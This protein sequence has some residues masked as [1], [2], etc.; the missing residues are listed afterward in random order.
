MACGRNASIMGPATMPISCRTNSRARSYEPGGFTTSM[1]GTEMIA[2]IQLLD[3]SDRIRARLLILERR[4]AID[5]ICNGYASTLVGLEGRQD[6]F[7]HPV[8]TCCP[9]RH[10]P[11]TYLS[12]PGHRQ[13][14]GKQ[15]DALG[16]SIRGER[17]DSKN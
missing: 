6:P 9:Y 3:I 10:S 17:P 7:A 5:A 16:P 13:P 2:Q 11:S 14:R 8:E 1:S 15:L 4:A 12:V